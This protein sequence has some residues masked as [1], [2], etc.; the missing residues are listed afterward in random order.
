MKSPTARR[1]ALVLLLLLAFSPLAFAGCRSFVEWMPPE[2]GGGFTF[3]TVCCDNDGKNCEV[4]CDDYP[5]VGDPA[6]PECP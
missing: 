4:K 2:A 5:M 6:C 1:T 3:I